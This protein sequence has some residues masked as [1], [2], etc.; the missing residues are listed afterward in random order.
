MTTQEIVD[1]LIPLSSRFP[2]AALSAAVQQKEEIIPHLLGSLDYICDSADELLEKESPYD[3]LFYA[4]YLLAQFR[5]KQAFPKLVRLLRKS[6]EV[7]DYFLGDTITDGASKILCSVY[8]GNLG[9]LKELI[10]D[11]NAYEYARNA[12]L[13]AYGFIARGDPAAREEMVNYLRHFIHEHMKDDTSNMPTFV[14]SVVVDEHL[15]ELIP[16]IKFLY[17]I[18]RIDYSFH[19]GYDSFLDF[20]FDYQ[21]HAEEIFIDDVIE[22]LQHWAKYDEEPR[23]KPKPKPPAQ[24]L[25]AENPPQEAKKKVGRNEP[26]PCGSGK[27]YKK[28]CLHLDS[29]WPAARKQED[30][31]DPPD[32]DADAFR[33][34][35]KELG[36]TQGDSKS[37]DLMKYYPRQGPPA[38]EGQRTI[39]DFY[40]PKAIEIDIPVYK[41]L[42]HR[43][44]P[45][46]VE[47]NRTREDL[48]RIGFLLEAFYMF[49][50]TCEE[51]HLETFDE[52]D[53]K[54]MVHY[55]SA[56]WVRILRNLMEEYED[57]I[58]GK[59]RDARDAVDA[60]LARMDTKEL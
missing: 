5:E 49:T 16:D 18:D 9:L 6:E 37:Y 24:K 47:R 38:E 42:K 23:P 50:Q 34:L 15:F 40:S 54:Y 27:K 1:A 39:T 20:M 60:A 43:S 52:Y 48:E 22:E 26:C 32:E 59:K 51:E 21:R 29:A 57:R 11:S 19:G 2:R 55:D 58:P 44:I 36:G 56:T 17:D 13:E 45:I 4:L 25:M 10:E 7:L 3:L 35:F 31:D 41:A 14:S 28:C 53:R 30:D 12:A 46:W 33:N 8:D